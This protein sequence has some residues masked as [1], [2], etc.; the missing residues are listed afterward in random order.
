[1]YSSYPS[2]TSPVDSTLKKSLK[3]ARPA[4]SP[5]Q[6]ADQIRAKRKMPSTIWARLTSSNAA[7]SGGSPSSLEGD[8]LKLSS[9]ECMIRMV[10]WA[11][12][13]SSVGEISLISFRTRRRQAGIAQSN[14]TSMCLMVRIPRAG[15]R[16]FCHEVKSGRQPSWWGSRYT[17]PQ[18]DTVA[19]EATARS[20]TSKIIDIVGLICIIS[21]FGRQSFLLSSSTVFMF[22]IQMASTGPSKMSHLRS[23]LGSAARPLNATATTPSFHSW[24]ALSVSPYSW[25]MVT[26]FGFR[27]RVCTLVNNGPS[28]PFSARSLSALES[29][30]SDEDLPLKGCP[31]AMRP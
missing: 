25:P 15:G 12:L 26:A 11:M 27:M 18:R 8:S 14:S 22:S 1:M 3:R 9:R 29:T 17:M 13:L 10:V 19:G 20:P 4:P 21:E 24:V 2:G 5:V 23:E 28:M 31:T 6:P 16:M 7:P 30:A